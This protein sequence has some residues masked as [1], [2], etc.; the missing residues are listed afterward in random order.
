MLC[1]TNLNFPASSQ[2][3]GRHPPV[4]MFRCV[5]YAHSQQRVRR[6]RAMSSLGTVTV[7]PPVPLPQRLPEKSSVAV[8]HVLSPTPGASS[9]RFF[10]IALSGLSTHLLGALSANYAP[11]NKLGSQN[12]FV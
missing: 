2:Q 5:Y 1:R 10:R 4:V 6:S 8:K 7:M 11:N 9:P 3:F 12:R